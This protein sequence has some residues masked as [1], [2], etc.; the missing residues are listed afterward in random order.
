[1]GKRIERKR[2]KLFLL[3]Q[4]ENELA[5]IKELIDKQADRLIFDYDSYR[6]GNSGSVRKI[7]FDQVLIDYS[8]MLEAEINELEENLHD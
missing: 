5:S 7:L 1:M 4:L 6:G 2:I 3:H 8:N